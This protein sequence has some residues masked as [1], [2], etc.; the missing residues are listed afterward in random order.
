[1]AC[2]EWVLGRRKETDRLEYGEAILRAASQPR[3]KWFIRAGMAE[4]K[5]GLARRIHH[6][7]NVHPRGMGALA[8]ILAIG[9]AAL[10][11][12]SPGW[13]EEN[14]PQPPVK[15]P[16]GN[17]PF[18]EIES[19]FVEMSMTPEAARAF[20]QTEQIDAETILSANEAMDLL[21][22]LDRQKG[23][24]I[25]S[26][27]RVTTKSGQ[28]ATIQIVREFAYPTE[29]DPPKTSPEGVQM[30]VWP[31]Q[32]V[33]EPVGITIDVEPSVTSDNRILCKVNPRLVEF[34]GFMSYDPPIPVPSQKHPPGTALKS[35]A[36]E[37]TKTGIM[38]RMNSSVQGAMES[39]SRG[40]NAVPYQQPIFRRRE[41]DP[42]RHARSQQTGLRHQP[43]PPLRGLRGSPRI[44][45][46]RRGEMSLYG[47]AFPRPVKTY[48]LTETRSKIVGVHA[49]ACS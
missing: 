24:D 20:F 10:L 35:D 45:A 26:A 39:V 25:V 7:T 19:K 42:L 27:P 16:A 5:S 37:K 22:R 23:V 4:S 34:L 15:S 43:S 49:S 2:D 13:A 9:T 12:L 14:P 18:I 17:L 1:M 44:F 32:F 47:R 3:S 38:E 30:P 11:L 36:A 33:V 41:V 40:G 21:I 46:G 8:A 31:S 29:F 6:L 48:F 28:R